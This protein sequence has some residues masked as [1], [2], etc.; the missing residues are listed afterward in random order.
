MNRALPLRCLLVLTLAAC[1][2]VDVRT[3]VKDGEEDLLFIGEEKKSQCTVADDGMVVL[4]TYKATDLDYAHQGR[5]LERRTVDQ[6]E[7]STTRFEGDI[8]A[9]P[10]VSM[11]WPHPI[12]SIDD[13]QKLDLELVT[14]RDGVEKGRYGFQFEPRRVVWTDVLLDAGN[15]GLRPADDATGWYYFRPSSGTTFHGEPERLSEVRF[16][17]EEEDLRARDLTC[18]PYVEVGPSEIERLA[19]VAKPTDTPLPMAARTFT[20]TVRETR[21]TIRDLA[22]GEVVRSTRLVP[23][24]ACP[25][26]LTTYEGTTY[27]TISVPPQERLERVE[28][29][30]AEILAE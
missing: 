29:E 23:S 19:G 10:W 18:G 26:E 9:V 22:T 16:L 28:A 24:K 15:H 2:G 1:Q 27:E 13:E 20:V 21:I 6:I 25:E 14:S 7:G 3:C 12:R 8:L 17:V 5:P 11:L 4:G 30:I